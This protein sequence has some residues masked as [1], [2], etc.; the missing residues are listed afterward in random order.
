M[1]RT[2]IFR[3]A[4]SE[5]GEFF[6]SSNDQSNMQTTENQLYMYSQ[7]SGDGVIS[8]W[9]VSNANNGL[10]QVNI[11][12]G[13]GKINN[14]FVETPN[15]LQ[16]DDPTVL[17]VVA[18]ETN[19]IYARLAK[20][21]DSDIGGVSP[22]PSSYTTCVYFDSVT[23]LGDIPS[24]TI[25][26]ANVTVGSDSSTMTIDNSVKREI[27]L[28][29]AKIQDLLEYYLLIHK[30]DSDAPLHI[31]KI[32]LTTQITKST[33]TTDNQTYTVDDG[34]WLNPD[35]SFPEI[36]VSNSDVS[37]S[38]MT[39][40][41]VETRLSELY[42][43]VEVLVDDVVVSCYYNLY[44]KEGKII[45]TNPL[46][47][48]S[49]VRLRLNKNLSR[50][51][52][53]NKL[54]DF[55]LSEIDGGLISTGRLDATVLPQLSHIG[56]MKEKLLPS[57]KYSTSTT[58]YLAYTVTLLDHE[59][60][61][62]T[63]VYS[64]WAS[65]DT[66]YLGTS[67]GLLKTTDGGK[68]YNNI[69]LDGILNS[70]VFEI[71]RDVTSNIALCLSYNG[72]AK[73]NLN[74][75]SISNV[76]ENFFAE[77]VVF[78]DIAK[79]DLNNVFYVATNSGLLKTID[80]GETWQYISYSNTIERESYAIDVTES[81]IL[82]VSTENNL[83]KSEDGGYNW[84]VITDFSNKTIKKILSLFDG[85][86]LA[87][88][89]TEVWVTRDDGVNWTQI[90]TDN[91][92]GTINNL[93]YDDNTGKIYILTSNG[94]F[95]MQDSFTIN[96]SQ[97]Y[98]A[99]TFTAFDEVNNNEVYFGSK[100]A[101]LYN[102]IGA[103]D[104][105]FGFKSQFSH[106]R[107]PLVYMD[108][109]KIYNDFYWYFV[110]GY[111]IVFKS[112]QSANSNIEIVDS[113]QEFQALNGAWDRDNIIFDTTT[114]DQVNYKV[115]GDLDQ[116][117]E[118]F[119]FSSK[120]NDPIDSSKYIIDYNTNTITFLE[121]ETEATSSTAEGGFGSQDFINPSNI[122]T[123]QIAGETG[124]SI[125]NQSSETSSTNE[126]S[127]SDVEENIVMNNQAENNFTILAASSAERSADEVITIGLTR[128]D[129]YKNDN[130]VSPAIYNRDY[131]TGKIIFNEHQDISD[132]FSI[133]IYGTSIVNTGIKTHS[134]IDDLLSQYETGL[135]TEMSDIFQH[136]LSHFIL[137]L[138][139]GIPYDMSGEKL[140]AYMKNVYY[141]SF[142]VDPISDYDSFHSTLDKNIS[143]EQ[144]VI[145]NIF[146]S[147][148]SILKPS[149][150]PRSF[151]LGT[152]NGIWKTQNRGIFYNCLTEDNE[153][154]L[155]YAINESLLTKMHAGS[156][157]SLFTSIDY[158]DSWQATSCNE[159]YNLPEIIYDIFTATNGRIYMGTNDGIFMNYGRNST[160][161]VEKDEFDNAPWIQVGL[162]GKKVYGVAE[163]EDQ[164]IIIAAEDGI[165]KYFEGL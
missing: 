134:E 24:N 92:F 128:V 102:F 13:Q 164:N 131:S 3:L 139:H 33:T 82:Y 67:M 109:N 16:T 150:N 100:N 76:T 40:A 119:V 151:L 31:S 11:A 94:V 143:V 123:Q 135:N 112:P 38:S 71:I 165:Y 52:V 105:F 18:N 7:V 43:S 113:F 79:S 160:P 108:D 6:S 104:D 12:S 19:Y 41:Q 69:N 73:I 51:Q 44:P 72:I 138:K 27:A 89:D 46:P 149:T 145:P 91:S 117:S 161:A 4:A 85:F 98:V 97:I 95:L 1:Y 56:R 84:I 111:K 70:P 25:R 86:I 60:Q 152:N 23:D 17:S 34:S 153:I 42:S 115:D 141:H 163:D 14:V 35:N 54:E 59:Y 36:P 158:G 20:S 9:E 45:F 155:V 162:D 66:L 159:N 62:M 125:Y 39:D 126:V 48:G 147:V 2:A 144:E 10:F 121:E 146:K 129:I 101:L 68:N 99:E 156:N 5:S 49:V 53:T 106:N 57:Q 90:T 37:I 136:N 133:S 81:E 8:G 140:E 120:Y 130:I 75:D 110:D 30:H 50:R 148:Y 88:T 21:T 142:G 29:A 78:R 58:D 116:Y 65:G 124:G 93:S 154:E 63:Y 127:V 26:I 103:S 107:T 80:F 28:F 61:K 47:S 55:R 132:N 118:I 122:S 83:L 96:A 137:S 87:A 77:E 32:I 22:Y 74:N 64:I 157:D 15:D 114:Y